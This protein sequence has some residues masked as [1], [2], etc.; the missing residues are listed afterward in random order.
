M[1][2]DEIG[3]GNLRLIQD[4]DEFC[5]GTDAVLLARFVNIEKGKR[6]L[7]LCTGNGAVA[8]ML[9]HFAEPEYTL[10]IDINSHEIELANETV[11][12]NH[13]E[14]RLEFM[15]LDALEI[16]NRLEFESFDAVTIN[17]P[18]QEVGTGVTGQRDAKHAARFETTAGLKDFFDAASFLL[19]PKGSLFMVHRPSRLVDIFAYARERKLEPKRMQMVAPFPGEPANIVLVQF[20]KGGG[21]ELRIEPEYYVRK[22]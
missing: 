18:Y 20:I 17:P 14:G 21:K 1:R 2:I 19:K 3:F 9:Q 10:G 16:K 12:L 7:D 8:L 15:N 5:Y 13:L 22:K 4:P 6:V 11:K